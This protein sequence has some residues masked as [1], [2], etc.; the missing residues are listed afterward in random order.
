[1]RED[2][3]SYLAPEATGRQ[4]RS[5]DHRTDYYGVGAILFELLTGEPPFVDTDPLELIH[6]ILTR[7]PA[8]ASDIVPSVPL[9]LA[10]VVAKLLSKSPQSRYQ[11]VGGIVADLERLAAGQADLVIG[12]IDADSRFAISKTLYARDEQAK[13]LRE[14]FDR[15]RTSGRGELA[16]IRGPSG[17]GKSALVD[18]TLHDVVVA[19]DGYLARAKFNQ[20]LI[21]SPLF[22]ITAALSTLLRRIFSET[23]A[24]LE[25]WRERLSRAMGAEARV[26]AA[27]LPVVELVF[28]QGW[29]ERQPA[30]ADLPPEQATARLENLVK[31]VFR[32]FAQPGQ[33]LLI[34]LDDL[35]R[36]LLSC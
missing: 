1:M 26:I 31:S 3:L 30:I 23:E 35:V 33:P 6:Q 20:V 13:Q 25:M 18:M 9:P 7:H 8:L 5:C 19:C 14:A 2:V 22:A 29:I 36:P 12:R 21:S 32:A 10:R 11:S 15:V 17:V 16:L 4:A 27:V 34:V 28:E 24:T